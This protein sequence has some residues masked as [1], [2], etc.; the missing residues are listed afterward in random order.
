[1]LKVRAYLF[2][3]SVVIFSFLN[4][5][6]ASILP[7]SNLQQKLE[8]THDYFFKTNSLHQTHQQLNQAKELNKS[9]PVLNLDIALFDYKLQFI[10]S[11][12][13]NKN[14]F[15]Y[16]LIPYNHCLIDNKARAPPTINS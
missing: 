10:A 7:H 3:I 4:I 15:F 16:S 9:H 1:M 8:T 11:Y 13:L 14:E 2:I 6:S 12:Q 5:S